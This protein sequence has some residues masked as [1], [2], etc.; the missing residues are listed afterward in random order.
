MP[1]SPEGNLY[2]SR[3]EILDERNIRNNP[4]G[5][6]AE[7]IWKLITRNCMPPQRPRRFSPSSPK[8]DPIS[9]VFVQTFYVVYQSTL[10]S[11]NTLAVID[12]REMTR[13]I[14]KRMINDE[15]HAFDAYLISKIGQGIW[16]EALSFDSEVVEENQTRVVTDRNRLQAALN[17]LLVEVMLV[18]VPKRG[19]SPRVVGRESQAVEVSRLR[20]SEDP[21][22][23]ALVQVLGDASVNPHVRES[24]SSRDNNTDNICILE[25]RSLRF[26]IIGPN[27]YDDI[28]VENMPDNQWFGLKVL[29]PDLG[30]VY[31]QGRI[32]FILEDTYGNP[33][34]L[35]LQGRT[36]RWEVG[37]EEQ[38]WQFSLQAA[39]TT[40]NTKLSQIEGVPEM[41]PTIMM[42]GRV[43]P[44][45]TRAALPELELYLTAN[46]VVA[47]AA[48]ELEQGLFLYADDQGEAF[49]VS[50][51]GSKRVQGAN[52][53]VSLKGY[54]LANNADVEVEGIKYIWHHQNI[55]EM[56]AGWLEKI[57]PAESDVQ[58][59]RVEKNPEVTPPLLLGRQHQSKALEYSAEAIFP[60]NPD[61]Y[62]SNSGNLL[63]RYVGRTAGKRTFRFSLLNTGNELP[64]L[65]KQSGPYPWRVFAWPRFNGIR[66]DFDD[67]DIMGEKNEII[68]GTTFYRMKTSGTLPW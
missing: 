13:H 43:L 52:S 36:T 51:T 67:A 24:Q 32:Q 63:I 57:D 50:P 3:I 2:E 19:F 48:I 58:T 33:I 38:G 21:R 16:N 65:F 54:R 28:R 55:A 31:Q 11:A 68:F 20:V 40:P 17:V 18:P 56:T 25:G 37:S 49:L 26:F 29:V 44:R 23:L 10:A 1:T 62:L 8:L 47:T 46:N 42:V 12:P 30:S 6:V 9:D 66:Y 53:G 64:F 39:I 4:F 35:T 34:P 14:I 15:N 7:A 27:D 45:K 22:V 5:A 60:N 59:I 41:S 61:R